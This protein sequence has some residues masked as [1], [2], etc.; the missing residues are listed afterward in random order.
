MK[1]ESRVTLRQ[2]CEYFNIDFETVQELGEYGLYPVVSIEGE[3]AIEIR[4][5]DRFERVISLYQTLGI[6]KE[7][8]DII[9]DLRERIASLQAQVDS[10]QNEVA[11]LKTRFGGEDPELLKGLGLLIEIGE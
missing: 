10:L 2:L 7:G 3:S 9:L 5:L 11:K 8:I 4:Y 1:E 6:N